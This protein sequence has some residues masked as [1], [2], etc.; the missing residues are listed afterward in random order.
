MK[1]TKRLSKLILLVILIQTLFFPLFSSASTK[2]DFDSL[3]S[4]IQSEAVILIESSTGKVIY[5]K[6]GEE[7]NYPAST[8]KILAAIIAIEN[9]SLDE[10]ATVSEYAVTSIPSGYTNANIQVG[11]SLSIRDLLYAL[12]LAS[13]NE[14]AV[15]IGEHISGSYEEFVNLMN[16]KAIEI[17]CTNSHFMNGN[18]IHDDNHYTT[19]HDLAKIAQYCMKNETFRQIVATTSYTLPATKLYPYN[20]RTFKNTNSLIIVNNNDVENNYYYPYAI[21]IKTGFT[22]PAG[23]CLVAA[24]NNNGL[25]FIS[26]VLGS[27]D[28][29]TRYVDAINMFNFAFNNYSFMKL[30]AKSNSIAT[31]NIENGTNDTKSL[32]LLIN[33]D[34]NVLANL[35]NR[36]STIEPKINLKE[37][38]S[39]PISKGDVVGTVTYDLDGLSYTADL[40][41]SHDVE[42]KNNSLFTLFL[43]IVAVL[44]LI[45]IVAGLLI[46]RKFKMDKIK[47][48]RTRHLNNN[49]NRNRSLYK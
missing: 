49:N 27:P 39:A 9:C 1:L 12:M 42:E 26:V 2:E 18:G 32:D 4:S 3:N 15:I 7:R 37:N 40:I 21:G 6:N 35:D 22:T 41:A 13:A 44:V 10:M 8:T 24:A 43:K 29:N 38:L 11:E 47:Y 46:K 5:S 16:E 23:N 31:I 14:A 30:Q 48:K 19:A 25:E 20:D 36:N 45:L 28:K 34:V 17:G 33:S